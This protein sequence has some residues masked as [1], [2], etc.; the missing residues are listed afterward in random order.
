MKITESQIK[1]ITTSWVD[2]IGRVFE[3]DN[4][5]FRVIYSEKGDY[6]NKL[7]GGGL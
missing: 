5:L 6:I 3:Y 1:W 7:L 2:E 4:R